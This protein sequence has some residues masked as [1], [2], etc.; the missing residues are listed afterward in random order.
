MLP[1]IPC[2]QSRLRK[3]PTFILV[4]KLNNADFSHSI[5]SDDSIAKAAS[6]ISSKFGRL[7]VLINNAGIC[8][9]EE[10][11]PDSEGEPPLEGPRLRATY[12]DTFAVN[13]FST[14]IVTEAFTS[15]LSSSSS[16]RVVFMSSGL[17]SLAR[18][19][20]AAFDS[21]AILPIYRSSKTALNML[22]LHYASKYK[23][24]GWKVN[25]SC[26]G[27]C[28]TNLNKFTGTN[29]AESGAVNAVRLAMLGDDGET[30]TCSS[31]EGVVPW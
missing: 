2:V 3:Y 21:T 11:W 7:D 17:S 8:M 10:G 22:M 26:P 24:A 6:I 30:G 23:D 31:K 28:S 20:A 18:R 13:T 25:A 15:L 12:H 9:L 4:I 1:N 27:H 19:S 29:S 5:T 16:P 14:A